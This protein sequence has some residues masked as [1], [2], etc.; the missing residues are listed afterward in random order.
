MSLSQVSALQGQMLQ[1]ETA[2]GIPRRSQSTAAGAYQ[3]MDYVLWPTANALGLSPSTLFDENTQMQ[4]GQYRLEQRGLS[5]YLNRKIS[6]DKFQYNLS[7]EWASIAVPAGYAVS[8]KIGGYISDGNTTYYG[9]HLGTTTAQIQEAI[10]G[11][12][13]K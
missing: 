9:Q 12:R 1:V 3:I 13:G 8:P 5:D 2:D 6:A 10:T 7:K 11:L 4:M